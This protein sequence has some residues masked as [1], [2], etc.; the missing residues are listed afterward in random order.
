MKIASPR[1][2]IIPVEKRDHGSA[3]AY[4]VI[5][6]IRRK[7]AVNIGNAKITQMSKIANK[8]ALLP[9]S[10]VKVLFQME[11]NFPKPRCALQDA[12]LEV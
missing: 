5:Q 12:T 1:E 11:Q 7:E 3:A 10:E 4:G 8:S 2:L 9:T 6:I